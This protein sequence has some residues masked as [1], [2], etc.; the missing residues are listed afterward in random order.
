MN[1][2]EELSSK[3]DLFKKWMT[4]EEMLRKLVI[5]VF[6]TKEVRYVV[7]PSRRRKFL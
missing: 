1:L 7:N 2:Q 5:I 6:S 3:Y 4:G